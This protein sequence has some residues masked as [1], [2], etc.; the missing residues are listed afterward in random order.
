MSTQCR[1]CDGKP[2][3]E[4]TCIEIGAL[5]KGTNRCSTA[6]WREGMCSYLEDLHTCQHFLN[7]RRGRKNRC[8]AYCCCSMSTK[9]TCSTTRIQIHTWSILWTFQGWGVQTCPIKGFVR[10]GGC[11]GH[12]EP[13]SPSAFLVEEGWTAD[14]HAVVASVN[15]AENK[16]WRSPTCFLGPSNTG[17]R[18]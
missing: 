18:L 7:N 14:D 3:K 10:F 11:Q 17:Y 12:I 1:I 8:R 5:A 16:T 2:E 9:Q 15:A 4:G 6:F 13:M